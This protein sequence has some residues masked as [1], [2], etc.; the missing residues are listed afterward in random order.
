MA[1][2][3]DGLQLEITENS[4]KAVAGLEALTQS[5]EKLKKVTSGLE[6][7]LAGVN[8]DQFGQQIK[9]LSTAL[10]PLQGFKTQ[11]GSVISSLRY[12]KDA[13]K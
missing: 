13:A 6:K 2:T 1:I 4:E 5:L 8:F 3:I 11:A 10:Q 9:Q 7:S 12:F